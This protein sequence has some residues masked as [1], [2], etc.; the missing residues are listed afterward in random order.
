MQHGSIVL[1]F[2]F[3]I[4]ITRVN[5]DIE[6]WLT[7]KFHFS[8]SPN[9]NNSATT[10]QGCNISHRLCIDCITEISL[11]RIKVIAIAILLMKDISAD[12]YS[13]LTQLKHMTRELKDKEGMKKE[14]RSPSAPTL[15]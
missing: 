14:K 1:A 6:W 10:E 9:H 2:L 13:K 12:I 5:F 7:A 8:I 3:C 15:E 4:F 11:Q